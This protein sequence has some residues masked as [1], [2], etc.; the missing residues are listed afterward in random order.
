MPGVGTT[1]HIE[2]GGHYYMVRP[3][4]YMK[5]VAPQFGARFS[6]GDPDWNNL[7]MWQHWSQKCFIGGYDQDI[8]SDDAM[9][10]EGIGLDTTDHE[11][12]TLSRDLT[13]GTGANW[14]IGGSTNVTGWKAIVYNNILYVLG[15]TNAGVNS[16]LYKYDP[17]TDGWVVQTAF[18]DMC[19]RSI[20]TFDGK[21]FI[22]G[23]RTSDSTPRLVYS[24]G[25]IAS[26][27]NVANPSSGATVTVYAM[28]SFQQ[29]LYVA[30]GATI[31]RLKDDLTWDGN[32]LF[33]KANANSESNR[34][35]AMEPHL[36]FLYMISNNGH[37]HRTDGNTTFDIWNWD[38]NTEGVAIRSFDG[39]L[40]VLTFEYTSATDIGYGVLYQMSGSAVTQLKRFGEGQ[41]KATRVGNLTVYDRRLF[42]GASNLLGFGARD[43][44]GV[45]A[46]DP[47]ED[48]HSVMCSN[49]DTT[50]YATGGLPYTNL[51]VDDQIFFNQKLFVFV[52]GHG[53]FKTPYQ[54]R[55]QVRAN[56]TYNITAIGG[57]PG[58]QNGGWLTSSTYDAGTAGVK[59]LWRKV[60]FD[61]ATPTNTSAA[62]EYS[63][64]NGSTWTTIGTLTTVATRRDVSYFLNNIIGTSFKLRITLRSTVATATPVF[65]GFV[66]SYLPVVEPNWMWSFTIVLASK[67]D[68]LDGTRASAVD[69]EAEFA[70]LRG[71]YRTKQLVHFTDAE[72]ESWSTGG[73]PG[74]LIYDMTIAMR[75]LNQPLEG[76]VSIVLLESVETY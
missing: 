53:A 20:G 31:F 51:I 47:I 43:G 76:E 69:T 36:G 30:Y 27:T 54:Y 48:A 57:A 62:F 67:M 63:L 11:K 29:R 8:W 44:F 34:I 65:Y 1:H 6:T 49:S 18:T 60:S 16:K 4:S 24:S 7:S 61:I 50:T 22:G 38:G 28:R 15:M 56:K 26:Y 41:T 21:L 17:A 3:G 5:K 71:L 33:Y 32:V 2:L 55:D 13:K 40:F 72:G 59:K 52:R 35:V 12:I 39:R 23:L 42:Y 45:A 66:V 75:D 46:Y 64:D 37:I 14:N 9:Y 58:P 19:A 25:A 73:Q 10:D 70:F 68:L 74:A